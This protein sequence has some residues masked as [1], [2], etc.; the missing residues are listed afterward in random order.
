M[1]KLSMMLACALLSLGAQAP[2]E[3]AAELDQF[4]GTWKTI[5][6]TLAGA[7]VLANDLKDSDMTVKGDQAV[8]ARDPKSV[9][10]LKIDAGKTPAEIDFEDKDKKVDRG[11]YRFV[12]K[13]T[14]EIC[15]EIGGGERPKEF[16]APKDSKRVLFVLKRGK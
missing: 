6:A 3:K 7:E 11:I 15:V 2:K 14:L 1:R 13:D 4:Q 8:Q 16:A 5:K 12:D 10:T 9:A